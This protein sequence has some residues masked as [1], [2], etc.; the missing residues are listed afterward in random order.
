M[1]EINFKEKEIKEDPVIE[2]YSY[3]ESKQEAEDLIKEFWEF[4]SPDEMRRFGNVTDWTG[5]LTA[6]DRTS[7]RKATFREAP[8]KWKV[9]FRSNNSDKSLSDKAVE[10]LEGKGILR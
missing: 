10:W 5:E 1:S 8:G 2:S 3:V 4:V 7:A 9:I 6:G